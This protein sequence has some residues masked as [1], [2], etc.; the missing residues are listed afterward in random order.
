M[1]L[2]FREVLEFSNCKD[3]QA[4]GISYLHDASP[5]VNQMAQPFIPNLANNPLF[6]GLKM[7]HIYQL[8]KQKIEAMVGCD[9]ENKK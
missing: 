8:R 5:E 2:L 3:A 1:F 9:E 4:W 6:S 7:I